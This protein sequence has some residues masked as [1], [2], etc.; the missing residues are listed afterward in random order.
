MN[1]DLK[2][3]REIVNPEM[4]AKSTMNQYESKKGRRAVF[5]NDKK[6][7]NTPDGDEWTLV[8]PGAVVAQP[9]VTAVR[10]K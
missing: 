2:L 3:W 6:T 1:G 10:P 9:T 4:G 7:F 5:H 8:K